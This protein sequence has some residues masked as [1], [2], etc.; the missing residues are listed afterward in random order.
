MGVL[1]WELG[2]GLAPVVGLGPKGSS[3][4][5]NGVWV[6]RGSHVNQPQGCAKM[7]A[8]AEIRADFVKNHRGYGALCH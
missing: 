7:A 2:E 4:C 6:W 1:K 3:E 8:V 5:S